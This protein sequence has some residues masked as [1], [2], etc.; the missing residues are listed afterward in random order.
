MSR[1]FTVLVSFGMLSPL[2]LAAGEIRCSEPE[3]VLRQIPSTAT[4]P[5][6]C[7]LECTGMMYIKKLQ[8]QDNHNIKLKDSTEGKERLG[9]L[10]I[11]DTAKKILSFVQPYF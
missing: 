2:L 6:E 11:W 4:Q 10:Q 8:L 7:L 9:R 3:T 5:T 1:Y